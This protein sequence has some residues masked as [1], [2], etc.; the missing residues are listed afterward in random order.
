MEATYV[1]T[2]E[3]DDDSF[4]WLNDLRRKHFPPKRNFLPA[5]LT[6]FHRLSL[7]QTSRLKE[8]SLPEGPIA[9]LFDAPLAL[10]TGVAIRVT[11]IPL[12]QLRVAAK[13]AMSGELS[14][15]DS[16]RWRPHVTI[17]NKVSPDVARQLHL[18]GAILRSVSTI[19]G[20][21]IP[22]A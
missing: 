3:M 10:G 20:C 8:L 13:A 19:P 12:E 6:M 22:P 15:Q 9:L 11:S 7:A 16:Q 2:A 5:H 21:P 17:Q 1:L 18:T 14:R 4:A